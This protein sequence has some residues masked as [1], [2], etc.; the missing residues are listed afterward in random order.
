MLNSSFLHIPSIGQKTERKIWESGIR[1]TDEFIKSPADSI[2]PKTRSKILKY[3]QADSNIEDPHHYYDNLP[4][5]EQ[6]RIFK[7]FQKNTAYI[8]I[9][10]TGLDSYRDE[11]TTIAL[12]DG[13]NIKHYVNG[14]N[15][16][17]FKEDIYER[18]NG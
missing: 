14:I 10:T 4:S 18:I 3:I 17:K 15:L 11:I 7:R 9:E 1:T 6:W 13:E 8:D 2:P 16:E 12:Y 5:G